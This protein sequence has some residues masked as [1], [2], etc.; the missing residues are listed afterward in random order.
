MRFAVALYIFY[1]HI[2]CEC[3]N[4]LGYSEDKITL[5]LARFDLENGHIEGTEV[6][7]GT[8]QGI[9]Y[10]SFFSSNGRSFGELL[11]G[12]EA[13]WRDSGDDTCTVINIYSKDGVK[14]LNLYTKTEGSS[15][16]ICFKKDGEEKNGYEWRP[17]KEDEFDKELEKLKEPASNYGN[18][19]A[20][21]MTSPLFITLDLSSPNS[22]SIDTNTREFNGIVT[23][24]YFPK[25]GY[26]INSVT[27]G[28][29]AL[30]RAMD[31]ERCTYVGSFVSAIR[32]L[33]SIYTIHNRSP[34]IK[35]FEKRDGEWVGATEKEFGWKLDDMNKEPSIVC[36]KRHTDEISSILQ[37]K[38]VS[39][40]LDISKPDKE[41]VRI[42]LREIENVLNVTY[43]P[44]KNKV[45][46]SVFDSEHE[47]WSIKDP[48]INIT[49]IKRIVRDNIEALSIYFRNAKKLGHKSFEKKNGEWNEI[50]DDKFDELHQLM[51]TDS[52]YNAQES[53]N[54]TQELEKIKESKDI[55]NINASESD[56]THAE[57][58]ISHV[59]N[60]RDNATDMFQDGFGN[61]ISEPTTESGLAK[62]GQ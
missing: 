45:I 4:P 33:V 32:E 44:K 21:S 8:V 18:S 35:F 11:D 31:N 54:E 62:E 60:L 14:L 6:D 43:N 51:K 40:I 38:N 3:V 7:K 24:V 20:H 25:G 57:R 56:G 26:Y 47:L 61:R 41:L 39:N 58:S 50:D 59:S 48:D 34:T 49:F 17:I 52:F 2:G 55:V 10:I 27:E 28:E 53:N 46:T 30:W 19:V 23:R 5:D 1:I 9:P 36:Y 15:R 16:L 22:S 42:S 37:Q 13:L 12:G 29:S